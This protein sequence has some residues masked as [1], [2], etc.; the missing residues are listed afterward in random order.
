MPTVRQH[1]GQYPLFTRLI[2]AIVAGDAPE[3]TELI[4][5]SPSLVRQCLAEG[6]TRQRASDF[7]FREIAHYLYP[8]ILP[9]MRLPPAT[10]WGLRKRLLKRVHPL[11]PQIGAALNRRTMPRTAGLAGIRRLRLK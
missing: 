5:S 7:F 3:V 1:A 2:Q 6:A 10:D 8:G 9:S 4:A 11:L